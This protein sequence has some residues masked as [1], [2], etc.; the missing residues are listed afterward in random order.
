[1]TAVAAH[2]PGKPGP[3]PFRERQLR[4]FRAA[5]DGVHPRTCPI[6]DHH[7]AFTVFGHPPR[8]DARCTSCAS[9]ERHRLIMLFMQRTGFFEPQ[10]CVLHFAPEAQLA[11]RIRALVATYETADKQDREAL[12]HCLDIEDTRLAS[13]SYDRILCNHVLEHVDDAKALAELF[14]ILRPGGRVLITSPVVEGWAH[15]YE[16]PAVTAPEDRLVHFGQADHVRLY[17]RDIRDRIR[18]AG[19]DL[20]E[21]TAVEPD[22][23]I[24]GLMRGETL[25]IGTKPAQPAQTEGA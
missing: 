7:G 1:M 12:T 3:V 2:S 13:D 17:G 24:Y 11:P 23:H 8:Y 5:L 14:R 21:F 18:A 10:H 19:F 9:L 4:R 15:T 20:T 25:F 16:N 22:V 6:C